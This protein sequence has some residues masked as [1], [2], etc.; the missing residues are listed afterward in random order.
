MLTWLGAALAF[1]LSMVVF[2]TIVSA[3]TEAIHRTFGMREAGLRRM[4]DRLFAETIGDA[5]RRGAFVEKL[6]RNLAAPERSGWRLR[7]PSWLFRRGVGD[8]HWR[9]FI[10]RVVE[11]DAA[12]ELLAEKSEPVLEALAVRY[13]R[14]GVDATTFF[15]ERARSISIA[16]AFFAAFALNVDA[17][18]LF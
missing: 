10:R 11:N 18:T 7:L 4:L 14:F 17:V 5:G 13:E 3:L 12:N 1:S 16:L 2:S 15:E 9:E 6:T 8:L